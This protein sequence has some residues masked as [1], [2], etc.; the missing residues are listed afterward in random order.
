MPAPN[1]DERISRLP[2][3][4]WPAGETTATRLFSC[5]EASLP[6]IVPFL[7][8]CGYSDRSSS[9]AS[10]LLTTEGN[11]PRENTTTTPSD[12]RIPLMI[13]SVDRYAVQAWR[14]RGGCPRS[15]TLRIIVT[16][17]NSG[18]TGTRR[19]GTSRPHNGIAGGSFGSRRT[20]CSGSG[21]ISV[22]S[23]EL[24]TILSTK[25]RSL[26]LSAHT[27]FIWSARSGE[28]YIQ[29]YTSKCKLRGKCPFASCHKSHRGPIRSSRFFVQRC[30]SLTGP[31]LPTSLVRLVLRSQLPGGWLSFQRFREV[32][33]MSSNLF[34]RCASAARFTA[35][36]AL[37]C[38]VP[39]LSAQV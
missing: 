37:F 23:P 35:L 32:S 25:S 27:N 31:K 13:N 30:Q 17:H 38:A 6:D 12:V 18:R 16:R 14:V 20:P 24:I 26:S 3:R 28:S 21:W 36:F 33:C 7:G 19:I 22:S 2:K 39:A 10:P 34:L 15:A 4:D 5:L 9:S 11:G 1:D 29:C 8:K